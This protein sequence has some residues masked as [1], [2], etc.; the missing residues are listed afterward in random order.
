M[1]V[2][3]NEV[4]AVD[5]GG[6][7]LRVAR[8]KGRKVVEYLKIKT[9]NDGG[10]LVKDLFDSINKLMT[11]RVRGIGVSS[12]GP[13]L[14]GV[15]KNPPNL[16]LKNYNLRAALKKRFGLKVGVENDA[17]CVAIA[18]Q[19]LGFKGENFIILT[20]GT[21]I[22][23]GAIINGDLYIGRGYAPELGHIILD[24]N[25]TLEVLW[26]DNRRFNKKCFGKSVLYK[27]LIHRD[28]DRLAKKVVKNSTNILGRGIG[29][30][31]N[32][33][34]PEVVILA[35]GIRDAGPKFLKLIVSEAKKY[36]LI[37]RKPNVKW[38]K[39]DHPGIL[40]AALLV[41]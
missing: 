41:K 27:D 25:K 3:R 29:S 23:G 21:G 14:N 33:F 19:K 35:G 4:I 16:P 40:G 15:I 9:P 8:V 37:P 31:I 5:L 38:S 24:R 12:P 13:L 26:Q 1:G 11:K 30:L 18:E 34:D 20:L 6:T 22:G 2:F 36:I 39:L 17:N 10:E 32:V 7:N 28:K